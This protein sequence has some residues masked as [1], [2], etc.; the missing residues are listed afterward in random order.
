MPNVDSLLH[1]DVSK[2]LLQVLLVLVTG[3]VVSRLVVRWLPL[4]RLHPQHQLI[5][6]RLIKYGIATATIV[7]ILRAVG[8]DLSVLLGAAG[9]LTV[10]IGFASQTSASNLISGLFL[11]AEQPFV[12]GDIVTVGDSTGE[13]VS[14]ELLSVRLK[15]FDNQL[16]RIPNES[17]LKSNVTNVTHFPIR[18]LDMILRLSFDEDMARVRKLL[19]A[20]A[21]H[22]PICLEEPKPTF[23]Y[24][25]LGASWVDFRFSVW[26]TRENFLAM[27]NSIFEEVIAALTR[28]GIRMPS[29]DLTVREVRPAPVVPAELT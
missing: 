25:G 28:E 23:L 15:T 16:I 26:A 24:L 5:A 9:I 7:F 22:N 14:I 20:V 13:V 17:M 8:V 6:S 1:S 29:P 19:S 12:I 10:A 21:D 4:R 27:R 3:F 11:M 2:V 18:R